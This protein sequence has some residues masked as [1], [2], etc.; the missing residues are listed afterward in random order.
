MT[1]IADHAN[2]FYLK[3]LYL[4]GCEQINDAALIQL[5]KPRSGGLHQIPDLNKFKISDLVVQQQLAQ[6]AGSDEQLHKL[7]TDIR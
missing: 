6:I 2:P 3:E 7:M 4:D 5:T 1:I